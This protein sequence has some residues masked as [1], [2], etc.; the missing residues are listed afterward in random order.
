MPT[1]QTPSSARVTFTEQQTLHAQDL[2]AEQAYLISLRRLHYICFHGWGIVAGL[3][4]EADEPLGPRIEPGFAVDRFGRS[5]IVTAPTFLTSASSGG[6]FDVWLLYVRTAK[7]VPYGRWR[8]DVVVRLVA[9]NDKTPPVRPSPPSATLRF[10]FPAPDDSSVEAPVF[11]G[12]LDLRTTPAVD[13]SGRT[14]APLLGEE[15]IHPDGFARMQVGAQGAADRR[16]FVVSFP[17]GQSGWIDRLVIDTSGNAAVTGHLL[18]DGTPG[19][20]GDIARPILTLVAGEH[21]RLQPSFGGMEFGPLA[22]VPKVAKPWQIYHAAI[23]DKLDPKNPPAHQLRAEVEHPGT[24]D[25]PANYRFTVWTCSDPAGSAPDPAMVLAVRA[26]GKAEIIGDLSVGGQVL[27]GPIDANSG[28]PRFRDLLA[29]QWAA[30]LAKGIGALSPG[31]LR[32]V[33]PDAPDSANA[34]SP[35]SLTYTLTIQNVSTFAVDSIQLA[36]NVVA[37]GTALAPSPD[38]PLFRLDAGQIQKIAQTVS[39]TFTSGQRISVGAMAIGVSSTG[40]VVF[41]TPGSKTYTIT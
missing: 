25:N 32:L 17:D 15:V 18:S 30:G 12:R 14:Y 3:S 22:Q 21:S 38:P 4:V 1:I 40:K 36:Q 8:E 23:P 26:D 39:G 27:Q 35:G 11:M 19:Q 31:G 16:R 41:D 24:R 10:T 34:G 33:V 9:I 5:L 37:S 7:G 2:S 20:T 28:D 6:M 13:G 29:A